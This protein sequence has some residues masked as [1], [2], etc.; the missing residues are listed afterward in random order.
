MPVTIG[1]RELLA[2]LGGAA[3]AWPLAARAQQH[4]GPVR[5]GFLPIGSPRNAYDRS[6]AEAFQEGLR[7]VGLIE[8]QNIVLDV[9]WVGDDPD[10]AVATTPF[11]ASV[12]TISLMAVRVK[13]RWQAGREMTSTWSITLVTR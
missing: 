7:R 8:N 12:E 5:L 2:A 4:N 1:R 6:L 9:V 10:Q 3:A 11:R 13:T